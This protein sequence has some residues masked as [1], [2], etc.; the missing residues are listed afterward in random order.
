MDPI[1]TALRWQGTVTA[2]RSYL[3]PG[4]N[5]LWHIGEYITST[6]YSMMRSA[7]V[8]GAQHNLWCSF[9]PMSSSIFGIL[10]CKALQVLLLPVLNSRGHVCCEECTTLKEN[11]VLFMEVVNYLF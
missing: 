3:V 6:K 10:K 5:S 11:R 7:A 4:P 8:V 1:N 2:R 9:V